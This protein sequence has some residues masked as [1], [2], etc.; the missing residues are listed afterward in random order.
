LNR[1]VERVN[2]IALSRLQGQQIEFFSIDEPFLDGDSLH[3]LST[4]RADV[5]IEAIHNETPTGLPPHILSLKVDFVLAKIFVFFSY[6]K[7]L[8]SCSLQIWM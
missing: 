6:R 7:A 5:N 3:V 1:E 4:Y 8:Q 2:K